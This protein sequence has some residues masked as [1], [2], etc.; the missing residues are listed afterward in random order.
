MGFNGFAT[1]EW[2][3]SIKDD[4]ALVHGITHTPGLVI[5]GG[6]LGIFENKVLVGA[7][8]VSG[9]ST[10]EDALIAAAGAAAI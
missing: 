2:W 7:I 9:G 8:G 1:A 10:S 4:P 5:F 6:G 3:P